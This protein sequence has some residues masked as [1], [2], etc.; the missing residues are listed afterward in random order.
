MSSTIALFGMMGVGKT[1]VGA[2][3]AERLGR[4][5]VDTDDEVERWVGRPIPEIFARAGEEAFRTYE[6]TVV[7]ELSTV[8]DLVLSL[9][10]GTVLRDAPVADLTLTGVLIL[11]DAP[12]EVL[13]ERVGSGAG[14]PVL[15]GEDVAAR[16]SQVLDARRDRYRAVADVALDAAGTVDEVLEALLTWLREHRDVLTPSE[17]EA[18]MP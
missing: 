7:R 8:P 15:R 13:V 9:G 16:M 5:L 18:V 14:R 17:F 10:G 6:A 11:L 12:V 1:T 2:A 4:R 3:L